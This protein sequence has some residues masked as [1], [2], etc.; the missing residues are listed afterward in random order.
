MPVEPSAFRVALVMIVRDEAARV[1]RAIA[2]ARPF[3]D[4]CLVLD[5][6]S[7][8]D[9]VARARA[10][11][12]RVVIGHWR[13]D[14]SAAR[15]QALDLAGAD[16][17]L[18]LDA[19]EC[20]DDGGEQIAA[21]RARRPDFVGQLEVR[22]RHDGS[23]PAATASSWISRILPGRVRYAG[24]I[25]EQ[26]QHTLPVRRLP[27]V[28][29]HDGYLPAARQAKAGR[30]AALLERAVAESPGDA[31]LWYQWGKDHDVY[32]RYADSLRCLDRA[33]SLLPAGSPLPAW[34]HDL[35]VR[36]L[37]A[38]KQCARHAE[39]VT[40]AEQ[41]LAQWPGSPD[42]PFALGD[43]L[44]DWAAR[45]PAQADTLLPTIESAWLRCLALG[46][47]PD[48]E[49]TVAGRG[50]HL[51]AGNLALLYDL[52]GRPQEAAHYR[53]QARPMP[54]PARTSVSIPALP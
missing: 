3:V 28:V 46:E 50:S 14:F 12:A 6:G 11:G 29:T 54:V 34:A 52:L 27:V 17:H 8:D 37:H 33:E 16:W 38:L 41:A 25:H 23:D 9:T 1:E 18:V 4:D 20:L 49:G 45:E 32:E 5:T 40:R 47:Q 7:R 44:L 36:R 43:L 39:A 48:L 13:D 31:Y 15:N 21:L 22:S 24:R 35:A 53:A 26:P 2:S 19:D 30:N 51:A 10:A 42:V